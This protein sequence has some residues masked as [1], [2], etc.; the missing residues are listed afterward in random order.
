M[1]IAMLS[2]ESLHSIAVGGVATHVTEL[3]A[4]LQRKG[5]E[6][7]VFTR[8]A[9]GQRG[10]DWV[11]GV[12]YHRCSY[13]PHADFVDDVNNMCRA[14]VDRVFQVEDFVG[15]FDI[16]H[17]HDWLAANA[18]IWI[19]QGRGHQCIQTIHATE[20]ARCS[21]AF[22]NGRSQRIRCQERAGTYWADRVIAV[23]QATK[24]EIMW[25]Y[26]VP[27]WKTRVV[28][29]GVSPHRFDLGVD[30]GQ[31][32]RKY[33]IGPLD[34]TV[35]FCGRLTH[36]KGPDLLL[37]A[38]PSILKFYG[39]AKFVF[40]GD[41]EM[42]GG[43]EARA[44]Q[45]GVAHATRFLGFRNGDELPRMFGMS[46]VICVPSRNEPFGIVVLE[47]W[48]AHRPVVVTQIGGP[49]EYVRHEETGLK[50]YPRVDSVAWGLGTMFA[51]FDRARWMGENGR[52]TVDSQFTWDKIAE[53]T[54]S[55]YDPD[56][57]KSRP[58]GAVSVRAAPLG[59]Q[60][61]VWQAEPEEA[62]LET[63]GEQEA[64]DGALRMVVTLVMKPEKLRMS[65]S[66]SKRV[67]ERAF[68][69]SG[70][71][72]MF[73]GNTLKVEGDWD[74]LIGTVKRCHRLLRRKRKAAFRG[75]DKHLRLLTV[76]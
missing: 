45:L 73:Q 1:R 75:A 35:L 57:T 28:Y 48:S 32:K 53:Q 63:A 60:R 51:N 8:Q 13:P 33:D 2:W 67:C 69:N 42:R 74:V 24:N 68:A 4:A 12:H 58:S 10:H 36:Q 70:F 6:V 38:V 54:L 23:S 55:V 27:E 3:A 11:D 41:G 19:K 44:R 17:A 65:L 34:P 59:V 26:E 47:A 40:S 71:E 31:V 16:I 50:I 20:Y 37:E 76:G 18:M 56:G 49:S 72:S 21:N 52:R 46:D 64:A 43:L 22:H 30:P 25:M 29:N 5:H 14:F 66:D 39:N 61:P 7:H 62:A 15:H 9:P